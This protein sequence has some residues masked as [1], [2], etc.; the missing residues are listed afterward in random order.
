MVKSSNS[1]LSFLLDS[2]YID[3][4]EHLFDEKELE[5]ISLN[6]QK[7]FINYAEKIWL[8]NYQVMKKASMTTQI[9]SITSSWSGSPTSPTG[10]N[11]SKTE[12]AAL[13]KVSAEEWIR[14]FH[15]ALEKL[16]EGFQEL[17]ELKYLIRGKFG[18]LYNDDY[19]FDT[20][21]LSRASYYRLK[22]KVLEE[23]GRS[24]HAI[25]SRIK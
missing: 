24:L 25:N 1:Q 23:L 2:P 15:T 13:R 17:I 20:L 4:V 22:P 12:K 18:N 21:G 14:T 19:V 5:E 6:E 3:T 9:P 7:F 8:E 16:P 10:M 11:E